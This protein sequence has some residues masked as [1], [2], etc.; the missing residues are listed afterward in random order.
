[1][2]NV[3]RWNERELLPSF[4][5]RYRDNDFFNDSWEADLPAV[6][7]KENKK[8][9]KLEISAAGFDKGD[10]NVEVNKNIMTISARKEMTNEEKDK[11][12]KVLRQEF[13]S[14]SFSRSFTLPENVDT[15]HIVA[16]EKNGILSISLPKKDKAP[17]ET[18]KKIE[19]K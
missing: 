4:F 17:E 6:N 5:G 2:S 13:R 18:K 3:M 7:V 10:F 8:E 15:D 11:E 1:M 12:D 14:S 9:F 19:I 16:K